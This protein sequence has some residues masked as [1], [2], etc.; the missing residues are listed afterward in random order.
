[1]T[2]YGQF[3]PI[4]KAAQILA[5]RWTPLV[6]RELI[7]GSTRFN[8]LPCGVPLMSSLLLAQRLM[9]LEREG[10]IDRRPA[11]SAY[12]FIPRLRA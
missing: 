3:C 5:Q 6:L 2:G 10:V 11:A 4:A 7:C 8:E 1:M 9:F 12:G